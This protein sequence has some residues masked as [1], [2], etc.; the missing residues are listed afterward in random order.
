M[1]ASEKNE[2]SRYTSDIFSMVGT[3]LLWVYWPSFNAV[4]ATGD[5]YHRAIINTYISL[6]AS[7]LATFVVSSFLGHRKRF[8]IVDIQNATLSGGVAVGAIA[9][10]MLQPWGAFLAG[11][12]CGVVSTLGYRLFQ[13]KLFEKLKLHDT[14][15]IHNH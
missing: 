12:L 15:G 8:E 14:C 11:S 6:I 9:H 1:S 2:E 3:V 4:L 5:G 13:G 7:T 10:L